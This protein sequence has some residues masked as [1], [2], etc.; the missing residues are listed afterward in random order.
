MGRSTRIELRLTGGTGGSYTASTL[1]PRV[2]IDPDPQG[3]EG[4][5]RRP[6]ARIATVGSALENQQR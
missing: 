2:L 4:P 6:A 3:Y 1:T 5:G